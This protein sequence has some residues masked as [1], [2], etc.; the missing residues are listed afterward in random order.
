SRFW[1]FPAYSEF[2]RSEKFDAVAIPD[3]SVQLLTESHYRTLTK[4]D[5]VSQEPTPA[6]KQFV[7]AFTEHYHQI[8]DSNPLYA[9]LSNLFD[10]VAVVRLVRLL[11]VPRRIG[12][13]FAFLRQGLAVRDVATSPTMPGLVAVRHAEVKVK[14]N[15]L[16]DVVFPA[17]GGVSIDLT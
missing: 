9:D 17:W 8:A 12:W 7:Q 14:G 4:G 11:D 13:D 16:A 1:F 5:V 3:N 15:Q 6:A 10:W 2:V